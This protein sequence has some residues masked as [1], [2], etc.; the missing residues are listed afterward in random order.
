MNSIEPALTPAE[1]ALL[2]RA[3]NLPG[4]A[5]PEMSHQIVERLTA[6]DGVDFVTALLY[7]RLRNSDEHGPFIR[8]VDATPDTS[9]A[10]EPLR[11]LT[12]AIV[13]GAFYAEHP[14]TGA[15]GRFVL[16]EAARLGCRT[17]CVPLLSFGPLRE[18]ARR[19]LDWLDSQPPRPIVLVSLSKAGAEVRLALEDQS[20]AR[21]FRDVVAWLNLSGLLRGTAVVDWLFRHRLRALGVRLLFWWNDYSYAALRELERWPGM[22]Q[23]EIQLPEELL[24]VH[25]Y[26][27]PL[28]S[29]LS[30]PLARRGHRRLAPLGPNDGGASLLADLVGLPGRIYPI[31]GADH[32]LRPAWDFSSLLRRLFF[33]VAE[34][35]LGRCTGA[36]TGTERP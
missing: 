33:Y 29:H 16:S 21:R 23:G 30:R 10:R 9:E 11:D 18:N 24:T 2:E 5:W 25:V 6:R 28:V 7:D 13:P 20:A 27:F 35:R 14:E 32:Y 1:R 15:D 19:L 22:L 34:H 8:A 31:W 36:A 3:A 17:A 12:V 26:G 4:C